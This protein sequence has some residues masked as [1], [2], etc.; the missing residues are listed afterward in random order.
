MRLVATILF[1]FFYV[2]TWGYLREFV[3]AGG[4]LAVWV[5]IGLLSFVA[6]LV[7]ELGHALA[8]RWAGARVIN[9]VAI[10]LELRMRPM[11][12]GWVTTAPRRD[13][14][15]Y[16]TYTFDDQLETRRESLIIAAAGPAANFALALVATVFAYWC[17]SFGWPDLPPVILETAPIA[18]EPATWPIAPLPT[19]AE[20]AESFARDEQRRFMLGMGSV[21]TA[22][23]V[24]S[25]GLG[26]SN[27]VPYEHSDGA[28]IKH[29]LT[30]AWRR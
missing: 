10:P 9:I 15:G 19:S 16:V 11:R 14:G 28:A 3:P 24:L 30:P 6:I 7:H 22:L 26:V 4:S 23:A 2:P 29:A 20:I 27:L 13:I 25:A 17:Q 1:L 5:I 12:L 21:A 8:A 18:G